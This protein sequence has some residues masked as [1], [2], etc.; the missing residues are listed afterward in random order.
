MSKWLQLVPW[1]ALATPVTATFADRTPPPSLTS[2]IPRIAPRAVF[3]IWAGHGAGEGINPHY[4]DIAGQPKSVW[5]IPE[6]G[7][8][9]G[10][11]ARPGEYEHRV[12]GFFD[13]TLLGS[14]AS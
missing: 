12:V 7:H 2:L 10:L 11:S 14:K 6:A 1:F 3:L 4:Y 9:G 5:E 8:V 13:R